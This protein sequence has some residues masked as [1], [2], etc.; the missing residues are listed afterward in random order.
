MGAS[1]VV[2]KSRTNSALK[3]FNWWQGEFTATTGVAGTKVTSD[4][5][6]RHRHCVHPVLKPMKD[7]HNWLNAPYQFLFVSSVS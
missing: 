5:N 7:M 1:V 2:S 3:S 4:V 6:H